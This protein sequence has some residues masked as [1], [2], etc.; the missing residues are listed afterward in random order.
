MGRVTRSA[1][2]LA[3][4]LLAAALLAGCDNALFG[5]LRGAPYQREMAKLVPTPNASG[6]GF[7]VDLSG[8]YMIVGE[9]Y[10]DGNKGGAWIYHRVSG[11][12][13]DA[14]TLLPAPAGALGP[15]PSNANDGDLYGYAV[16][17][18]GDYAALGSMYAGDGGIKR[19]KVAIYGRDT[20]TGVWSFV[21]AF[22]IADTL[23]TPLDYDLFGSS[24]SIDGTWMAIGAR[25]DQDGVVD[26]SCGGVYLFQN[27]SGTWTYREKERAA[28]PQ[29]G[30]GFGFSVDVSGDLMIVGSHYEDIEVT[31]AVA[32][33]RHGAAYIFTFNT[34]NW[35]FTERITAPDSEHMA[36]FGVSVGISGSHAVVGSPL[37]GAGSVTQAGSAYIFQRSAANEWH[38]IAPA[39]LTLA[40]SGVG[41]WY[42]WTAAISG[43]TAVVGAFNRDHLAVNDGAAFVYSRIAANTWELAGTVSPSDAADNGYFGMALSLDGT[44]AAVGATAPPP[45][46]AAGAVYVF[47]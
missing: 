44:R 37:K 34:D 47:K 29:D 23:S 8:D 32:P 36:L 4:V 41:D 21:R 9:P 19:G 16:A 33:Y 38:T 40:S 2:S 22:G 27:S 24:I 6:Y 18:N 17:T 1:P 30:A 26:N 5:F 12:T 7:A 13:W 14:G 3:A 42:G 46:E 20:T 28:T 10:R 45:A 25:Q 39:V 31:P 15:D 43:D 11:E 35:D